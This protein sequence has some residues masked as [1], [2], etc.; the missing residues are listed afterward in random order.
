MYFVEWQYIY[1]VS[2]P[3]VRCSFGIKLHPRHKSFNDLCIPFRV[4]KQAADFVAI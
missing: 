1:T 2:Q 3:P 4:A